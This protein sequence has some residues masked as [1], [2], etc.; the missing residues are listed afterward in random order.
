[1]HNRITKSPTELFALSGEVLAGV[2]K[3]G[4]LIAL[5]QNTEVKIDAERA[6]LIQAM[7]QYATARATLKVRH[8]E[9]AKVL[10][11]A[12]VIV[13]KG[14]DL[15]KDEFGARFG[16]LWIQLNYVGSLHA[17][18]DAKNLIPK[19]GGLR[20]FYK[21]HPEK[22]VAQ[23]NLTAAEAE[24]WLVKVTNAVAAV[25]EQKATVARLSQIKNSAVRTVQRRLRNVVKEL[26]GLIDPLDP[27]WTAFGLNTPGA[28]AMADVPEEV[29]VIMVN[30]NSATVKWARAPRADYYRVWKRV[31]GT[32]A[33]FVAAGNPAGLDFIIEDLPADAE[34]EVAISAVNAGG[35]SARSPELKF[36]LSSGNENARARLLAARAV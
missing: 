3:H 10:R 9:L 8:Q 20:G 14:R 2:K 26:S 30:D 28:V 7:E 22:Q 21:L 33:E 36:N 1:M 32:D 27:R 18:Y 29:A 34:V 31:V 35:E 17:G 16:E 19:L 23:L 25:N 13:V 24:A 5:L 15:L 12:R 4:G 6:A 11:G